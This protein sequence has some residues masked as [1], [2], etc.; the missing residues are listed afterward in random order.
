MF[1]HW[2][3][4]GTLVMQLA[5]FNCWGVSSSY[6]ESSSH[7]DVAKAFRH[8]IARMNFLGRTAPS[9]FLETVQI[10]MWFYV[11]VKQSEGYLT[12]ILSYPFPF[13]LKY[14]LHWTLFLAYHIWLVKINILVEPATASR[15]LH[16]LLLYPSIQLLTLFVINFFFLM[17]II[18][19]ERKKQS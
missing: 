17:M 16:F 10:K 14:N 19:L 1:V 18:T 8:L 2:L 11:Y 15:M 13:Q 9:E 7:S 12:R 3:T 5:L 6:V 4:Y